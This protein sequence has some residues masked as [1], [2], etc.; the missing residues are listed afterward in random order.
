M[1]TIKTIPFNMPELGADVKLQELTADAFFEANA[2]AAQAAEGGNNSQYVWLSK[3]LWV[4]GQQFP[5]DEIKQWGASVILPMLAR[6][7]ELFPKTFM[8]VDEESGEAKPQDP[9]G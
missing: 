2:E 3:M 1:Y 6:M 8:E 5:A 9:N 4:D 7:R